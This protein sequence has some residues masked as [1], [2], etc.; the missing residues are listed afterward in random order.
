MKD[1]SNLHKNAINLL[2]E[3]LL[4]VFVVHKTTYGGDLNAITTNGIYRL[5]EGSYNGPASGSTL[6]G[7][8]MQHTEWNT[9]AAVQLL[10]FHYGRSVYYRYRV[11][12]VWDNWKKIATT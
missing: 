2:L 9:D 5:K 3:E 4:N 12:T 11:M 6:N 10:F 1:T 8:V 7:S